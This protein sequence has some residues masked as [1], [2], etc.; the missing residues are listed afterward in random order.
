KTN[1]NA[2]NRTSRPVLKKVTSIDHTRHQ[3]L[4]KKFR[5]IPLVKSEVELKNVLP[6]RSNSR[7]TIKASKQMLGKA[8]HKC[9]QH[10]S[11]T[12][13]KKD[14]STDYV[15]RRSILKKI[16]SIPYLKS[17]KELK[18]I[19]PTGSNYSNVEGNE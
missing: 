9:Q 12:V 18:N 16:R 13:L 10:T 4:L 5:S 7:G 11:R 19:L 1:G 2:S 8:K 15:R 3:S 17:E 14:K 6:T